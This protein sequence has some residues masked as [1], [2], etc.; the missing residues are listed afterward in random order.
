VARVDAI[1]LEMEKAAIEITSF[2]AS[3]N[4]NADGEKENE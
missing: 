4:N 3:R 1:T 2:F